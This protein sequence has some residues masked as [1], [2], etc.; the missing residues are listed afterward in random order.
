MHCDSMAR[1]AGVP[2]LPCNVDHEFN[3]W[4]LATKALSGIVDLL[5]LQSSSTVSCW[6]SPQN[7]MGLTR[8]TSAATGNSPR[9]KEAKDD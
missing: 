8:R 2:M 7:V 1:S 6:P 9:G 5:I 4:N 3:S